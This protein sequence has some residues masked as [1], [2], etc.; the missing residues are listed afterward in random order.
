VRP[1]SAAPADMI[2]GALLRE[3]SERVIEHL[4][5]HHRPLAVVLRR[6]RRHHDLVGKREVGIVD[7]QDQTGIDDRLVFL[8]QRIGDR[9]RVHAQLGCATLPR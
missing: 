3:A 2:A 9:E 7:L 1:V 4:D 6:L 5:A 8:M